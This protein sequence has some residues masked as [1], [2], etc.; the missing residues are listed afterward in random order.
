ASLEAVRALGATVADDGL[1]LVL[2]PPPELRADPDTVINCGNSGTTARLLAGLLAG[3]CVEV[4]LSGDESLRRRPMA[5]IIDPLAAMGATI[6]ASDGHLPMRVRGGRLLPFEYTLPV[7]SAQVK[8]ALLLAGLASRCAVTI[9]ETAITRDHTE[10]LLAELGEGLAVRKVRPVLV[11]DPHDPRKRRQEMPEPFKREITLASR[12]VVRGG[13]VDIPGDISTAAF[14]FAAAAISGK[15]I[16]VERVG[17]NPTRTGILEHL[18]GLGCRVDISERETVTGEPRGTVAV[19]GAPLGARRI[20]GETTVELVD[21]IPVIAVMAAFAEGTTVIRDAGE[22]RVKESDRL[23]AVADNLKRMGAKCGLLEDGLA[24]EGGGQLEG[25]DF[26]TYGDHRIAMAFAVA[27]LFL[28][29]PSTLDDDECVGVS[30][31]T[32]FDLL[33]QIRA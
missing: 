13:T 29:G 11:A 15:T 19:T 7:A 2:T 22:L 16:T 18:R 9:R 33:N 27:S 20:S 4:T 1:E 31:P 21:E 14:F 3:S 12:A 28:T 32:F 10:I 8:S 30:C 25:A 5:R 23:A 24:I 26:R 17:L 6:A